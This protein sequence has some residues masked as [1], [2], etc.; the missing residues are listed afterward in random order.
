LAAALA[1]IGCAG[2]AP[3]RAAPA[4][5]TATPLF[6]HA[7]APAGGS[8]Y[9]LGSVHVR[10][11]DA[12]ALGPEVAQAYQRSDQ[13][14]VEV[15]VS[16]ITPDEIEAQ[17]Q[18]YALLP[19]QLRL[20]ALLEPE[21]RELL[22]RF[23][24]AH[25]ISAEPLQRYE[26]WFASQMI[27]MTELSGAGYDA[28]LG[29][30]RS[31]V[32][33]ASGEK[34]IAGLETLASQFAMLSG[35]TLAVQDLMLRDVLLR[36]DALV[37][38]TGELLDAWSRGDEAGLERQILQP[39]D[40]APELASF[41]A[42]FFWQRNAAMTAR[43]VELARDGQTRFVVLGAGHMLGAK[44]IPALLAQQGFVVERVIPGAAARLPDA[45]ATPR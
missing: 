25:G 1:A 29:V 38:Y 6:W 11:A 32:D 16:Q 42:S 20:D 26:P 2:A 10:A 24:A 22:A 34:P 33:Q 14:V 12:P 41:Y 4:A 45:A 36:S 23:V 5:A 17:T 13:L 35:Q 9:L 8:F 44:G 21:T 18:R 15:D 27:L 28:A 43:L 40:E 30:D 19:P 37:A 31:F 7:Q 39:V 3:E